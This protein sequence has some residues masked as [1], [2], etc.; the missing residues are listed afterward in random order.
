[1]KAEDLFAH[2]KQAGH[3]VDWSGSCDGFK[4][5][6]PDSEVRGIAVS[7]QSSWPALK[8]AHEVGCNLFVTHEPT[9]YVHMDDDRSVFEYP[10]VRDK[11][12]WLEDTGMVIYRCHDV[13]D[14]IPGIGIVQAWARQLGFDEPPVSERLFY[15]AHQVDCTVREMAERIKERCAPIGQTSVEILGD[16]E[17]HIT[18]VAIGTGAI[19]HLQ[20]MQE[21]GADCAI[22]TDDGMA[23]WS[24]GCWALD[25]DYP[26]IVVNHATAEEPGMVTLA[27]YLAN[28]FPDVPVTHIPR[29][30]LFTTV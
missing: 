15:Q 26:L 20:T 12:Q 16:P 5:G 1:M 19:T 23:Y 30:C 14:A 27:E 13:W 29:G 7:W 25:S 4:A 18:C 24:A 9:F 17:K 11:R 21:M 28:A 8:M 3:F 10:H 22:L 2:M 6:N